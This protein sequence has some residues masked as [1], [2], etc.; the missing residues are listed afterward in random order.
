MTL[1]IDSRSLPEAPGGVRVSA[2]VNHVPPAGWREVL[3][4]YDL[5]LPFVLHYGPDTP[6]RNSRLLI[7]AWAMTDKRVRQR[8]QLAV[9]GLNK[10]SGDELV[11]VV[12]RLGLAQSVR[13]YSALGAPSDLSALLSAADIAALP[14]TRCDFPHQIFQAWT[15]RAAVLTS[16]LPA[17]A[18]IAGDAA[19]MIDPGDAGAIARGLTRL[20]KDGTYR[21][22]L[23][24][25]GR[26]R[27]A[28]FQ[29]Q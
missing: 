26:R 14:L 24:D 27:L 22:D 16:D 29:Y 1:A 21:R 17:I 15:T 18:E 5:S 2:P 10:S 12:N 28:Q 8:I 3:R 4:R 23:V 13:L 25:R 6:A 11:N 7:E 19:L 9:V 20:M